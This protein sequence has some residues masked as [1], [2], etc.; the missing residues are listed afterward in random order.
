[1]NYR[2]ITLDQMK[3][4]YGFITSDLFN[5]YSF[6]TKQKLEEFLSAQFFLEGETG[7][8]EILDLNMYQLRLISKFILLDMDDDVNIAAKIVQGRVPSAVNPGTANTPTTTN[9]AE[10]YYGEVR[11]DSLNNDS[12]EFIP[13]SVLKAQLFQKYGGPDHIYGNYPNRL[14]SELAKAFGQP[15]TFGYQ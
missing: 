14:L 3:Q 1:M 8:G 10:E 13:P 9:E 4:T 7:D 6:E 12:T 15:A 5:Q 2:F 11:K